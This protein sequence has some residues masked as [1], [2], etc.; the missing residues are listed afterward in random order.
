MLSTR[1]LLVIYPFNHH[2]SFKIH[3][4]LE[5]LNIESLSLSPFYSLFVWNYLL[6]KLNNLISKVLLLYYLEI[7]S[8]LIR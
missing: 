5:T 8:C 6:P 3:L 4:Y 1:Y 2:D 7:I